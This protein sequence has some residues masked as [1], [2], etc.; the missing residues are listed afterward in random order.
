MW[1]ILFS[2]LALTSYWLYVRHQRYY[3]RDY[4]KTLSLNNVSSEEKNSLVHAIVSVA[5]QTEF[6]FTY[7]KALEYGLFRTYGIP[8]ISSILAKTRELTKRTGKR[9]DD[10]DLLIKEFIENSFYADLK[11][12]FAIPLTSVKGHESR[13]SEALN[14]MNQI[15]SN[16]R[17]SNED[18]LYTLTVF[19]C[20]PI[21]WIDRFEWRPTTSNEKQA[22]FLLWRDIGARMGIQ[23]IPDSYEGMFQFNTE[24]EERHMVFHP[25]NHKVAIATRDLFVSK[26]PRI[27]HPFSHS[28]VYAL[29]DDRLRIAMG[30]EKPSAWL[31]RSIE[32]AM[33]VRAWFIRNWMLPRRKCQRRTPTHANKDGMYV[34]KFHVFDRT[35]E[36]GYRIQDLG[37]SSIKD[38]RTAM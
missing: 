3:N 9:Y 37:P 2:I 20:E 30:F 15:H 5:G 13:A 19:V 7:T 16:Y 11:C 21:R 12:P 1:T 36:N 32:A 22:I 18:Y 25:V 8:S 38:K 10:T 24:Y 26:I 29:M 14:R 33:F 6:P 17:I 35:Y 31:I 4:L 27:L 28:A 34:P 23:D